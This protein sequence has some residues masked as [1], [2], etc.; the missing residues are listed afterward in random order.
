MTYTVF[1]KDRKSLQF[2]VMCDGYI[3]IPRHDGNTPNQEIGLWAHSGGFSFEAVLTPYDVNG[4][5]DGFSAT[6]K[7]LSRGTKGEAY[8]EKAN[9]LSSK[10]MVFHN[11]NFSIHL[12]NKEST[13]NPYSPAEYSIKVS[14]TVGSTTTTLESSTVIIP[15]S[16]DES[17]L[18]PTDYLYNSHSAF[19]KKSSRTVSSSDDSATNNTITLSGAPEFGTGYVAYRNDGAEIGTIIGVSTNTLTF[20]G[21]ALTGSNTPT[22][23]TNIY[24]SLPKEPLYVN[25]PHHIAFNYTADGLMQLFYNGELVGSTTHGAGGNFS[26]HASDCYIG[27]DPDL[28][29][30]SGARRESQFMGELHELSIMGI[31]KTQ[32][33]ST[34][35][36]YPLFKD[37][38]LYMDFEEANLDG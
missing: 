18:S 8:F 35:T 13:N 37:T 9:R 22:N 33:K 23:G 32:F 3:T 16:I 30:S 15:T 1:S 7:S 38:L 25:T 5:P 21:Q 28:S 6:Q 4:N 12:E 17:S 20:L 34:N 36:L 31:S 19:A 27:Q 26:F 11:T 2:P 29:K 10:M 14:L 24:Y